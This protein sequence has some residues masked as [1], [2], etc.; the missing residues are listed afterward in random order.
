MSH[1][2]ARQRTLLE[3]RGK[4]PIPCPADRP[5]LAAFIL[6]STVALE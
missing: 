5:H 4:V 1:L 2:A 3:T 6:P